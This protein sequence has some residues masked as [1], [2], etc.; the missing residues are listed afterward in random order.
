MSYNIPDIVWLVPREAAW[1]GPRQAGKGFS[2]E[3]VR[4]DLVRAA[5]PTNWQEDADTLALGNAL[6][7]HKIKDTTP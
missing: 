7:L 5:M 4:A 3:Y 2:A 1:L 6:G